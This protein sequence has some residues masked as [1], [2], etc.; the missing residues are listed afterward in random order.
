[1]SAKETVKIPDQVDVEYKKGTLTV[2]KDGDKVEKKLNHAQLKVQVKNDK[3]VFKTNSN[4]K[5][6]ESIVGTYKTHLQNML[7][8]LQNPHI[9]KMKGVY[10]HFPMDI[11]QKGNEIHV[12]NFMGERNPRK[13]TIRDNVDVQIDGDELTLKSPDKEAVSQ[14]AA[15]I[16]QN[17]KKGNRDPRTF[18]DGV[19]ITE[20]KQEGEA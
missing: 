7:D 1:M 10:A 8:G 4:N 15:Q 2:E 6:V 16:E 13:T 17:C 3:V 9:Y 11:K 12:E 14:T 18:Q 19:Y 20:T 5:G